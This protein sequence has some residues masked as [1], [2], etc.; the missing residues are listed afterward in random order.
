MNTPSPRKWF[1]AL[2]VSALLLPPV[3]P[4]FAVEQHPT[5]LLRVKLRLSPT[6]LTALRKSLDTYA[7][8]EAAL[9]HCGQA[10]DI[11]SRVV[12][13]VRPCVADETIDAALS[14]FIRR[15]RE[16]TADVAGIDCS[17]PA[18]VKILRTIRAFFDSLVKNSAAQCRACLI[19]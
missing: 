15:V 4:A 10:S 2:V 19:C 18:K 17:D 14:L 13:A 8:F 11:A 12:Q 7:L 3:T 1:R 9:D 5:V 6:D 16:R